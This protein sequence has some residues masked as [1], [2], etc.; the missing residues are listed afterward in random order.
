MMDSSYRA[1]FRALCN[2]ALSEK[3]REHSKKVLVA[4]HAIGLAFLDLLPH[5][6]PSSTEIVLGLFQPGRLGPTI[7]SLQ[8]KLELCAKCLEF[9]LVLENLDMVNFED[10]ISELEQQFQHYLD[11]HPDDGNESDVCEVFQVLVDRVY[12]L[13]AEI[14]GYIHRSLVASEW[15]L[16]PFDFDK[17]PRVDGDSAFIEHC[18]ELVGKFRAMISDNLKE[19]N[20]PG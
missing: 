8:L 2:C 7:Y 9:R 18:A 20:N 4:W 16:E 1:E 11:I 17:D 6:N 13:L 15:I 14:K 10:S 12:E 3:A 5:V 19:I